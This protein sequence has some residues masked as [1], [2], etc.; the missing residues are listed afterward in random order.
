M[1]TAVIV[2]NRTATRRVQALGM[3]GDNREI[4]R[5]LTNASVASWIGFGGFNGKAALLGEGERLT[6]GYEVGVPGHIALAL[7]DSRVFCI[8]SSTEATGPAVWLAANLADLEVTSSG[9]VGIFNKRPER[10]EIRCDGWELICG[11]VQ[12]LNP[13][14]GVLHSG[15]EASLLGSLQGSDPTPL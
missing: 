15:R 1:T 12:S 8:V 6:P 11:H 4:P 5:P 7:S 10:I 2:Q 9:K 14:T 3:A 13:D